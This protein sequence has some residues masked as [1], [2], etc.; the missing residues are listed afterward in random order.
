MKNDNL[1]LG[2]L[3]GEL[4]GIRGEISEI[5]SFM[6]E[7]DQRISDLENWRSQVLGIIIG[8]STFVSVLMT[9][10]SAFVQKVIAGLKI[11]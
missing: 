7:Y 3:I 2:Q 10:I 4:K 5:K 1:L 6:K 9:I 8:F 11:N